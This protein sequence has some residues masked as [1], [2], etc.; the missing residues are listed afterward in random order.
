MPDTDFTID[1]AELVGLCLES[2]LYG[3][4]LVS[5][6]PCIKA[7]I[8][9]NSFKRRKKVN[10]IMFVVAWLMFA[11]ATMDVGFGLF[12]CFQGFILY[13]GPGGPLTVFQDIA[14]YASVMKSADVFFQ[15]LIGDLILIYRCWIVYAKSYFVIILPLLLWMANTS[16]GMVLVWIQSTIRT[17][18]TLLAG[19]FGPFLTG[20]ASITIV[21]N[22]ITTS[23]IV[24]RI[25]R[26]DRENAK[27]RA[28]SSHSSP[29]KLQKVMRI[30]IES[31][32]MYT[33]FAI[34]SFVTYVTNSNSFDVTTDMEIPIIGIAFN[35]IIIRANSQAGQETEYTMPQTGQT[36]IPMSSLRI[37]TVA[38]ST[39]ANNRD[40]KSKSA[41]QVTMMQ[42]TDTDTDFD[43]G[44]KN[45]QYS[46]D[47]RNV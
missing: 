41:V 43:A 8:W 22:I 31:G 4:Y 13:Q 26:V 34:I 6:F 45:D 21:Q 2:I 27:F 12:R 39:T 47:E 30:V 5:F 20:F 11:F 25:W 19:K 1:K 36:S 17:Q 10:W 44:V 38:S 3:I 15:V 29:T 37:A 16:C 24:W 42:H 18:T 7:L 33:T 40:P 32:L 28:P 14:N 46:H 35:L 9:D 23:L